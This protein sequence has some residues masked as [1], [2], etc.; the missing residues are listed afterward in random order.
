MFRQAQQPSL[1]EKQLAKL[2]EIVEIARIAEQKAK[3][4][5]DT[6]I[7]KAQK[8]ERKHEIRQ[9]ALHKQD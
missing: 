1:S 8:W 6:A 9:A 5:D 4:L 2:A 7:E 3:K